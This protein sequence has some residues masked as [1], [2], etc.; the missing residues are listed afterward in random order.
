MQG[1]SWSTAG[2]LP[3][4]RAYTLPL[5][6]LRNRGTT[7]KHS[8]GIPLVYTREGHFSS[9]THTSSVSHMERP[10]LECHCVP[11]VVDPKTPAGPAPA[12]ML[13]LFF[14]AHPQRLLG[15]RHTFKYYT[16]TGVQIVKHTVIHLQMMVHCCVQ[17]ASLVHISTQQ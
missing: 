4:Q 7:L 11:A 3:Y 15:E 8:N 6:T 14:V 10:P 17:S 5:E 12:Q 16:H 9:R 13:L 1:I 2:R